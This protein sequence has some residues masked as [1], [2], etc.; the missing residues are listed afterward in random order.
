MSKSK[1]DK[2]TIGIVGGM[3]SYATLHFFHQLLKA[4]PAEKE[5]DRPRIIIDN[6]CTMP[7]RVRAI[8]YEEERPLLVKLLAESIKNL[9]DAGATHIVLACNTSH[10]FLE[11]VYKIVPEARSRVVNIISAVAKAMQAANIKSA[12]FIATE[13]TIMSGIFESTCAKYDIALTSPNENDFTELR[14]LIEAVK[15]DKITDDTCQRFVKMLEKQAKSAGSNNIILG[16]T[17]FPCI[18]T[19]ALPLVEKTNLIIWD[20]LQEAIKILTK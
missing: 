13:G 11:E 18:Y 20:P 19:K 3:G 17:E 4:T 9:L 14:D 15:Q 1:Y 10:V 7:S 12:G 16:C 5:W 6:R 8:I 2:M